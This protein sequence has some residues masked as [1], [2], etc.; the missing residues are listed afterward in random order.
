MKSGIVAFSILLSVSLY[1]HAQTADHSVSGYGWTISIDEKN[2]AL[3]IA[4]DSLGILLKDIHLF[5]TEPKGLREL[6]VWSV[7]AK[8]GNQLSIETAQPRSTWTFSLDTNILR[9]ATSEANGV[10]TAE[11]PAS[12]DRVVARLMDDRGTPVYWVGTSEVKQTYGGSYTQNRSFLP[13]KN[14]ET[15]YFALGQIA[16]G[17]FHSL[18]D[19]ETDAA[20]DFG[21]G[22]QMRRDQ[23]NQDVLD[24]TLPVQG[25]AT[26]RII[27]DYYTKTLG[28]PFYVK[29]DDRFFPSAPIVWTSWSSY[30]QGITEDDIVRN[31][32]WIA[33]HLKPYGFQYVQLDDGY[34]RDKHGAHYWVD[35]WDQTRFPHGPQWLTDHIHSQ[36]LKAGIWLVPNAYAG[37]VQQHPDWY[38]YDKHGALLLDY[39]TPALDSTNPQALQLVKHIFTT[40][41]DW[42][43]DYYK[44]DG[45]GALTKYAPPVDRSRLH[46]PSIDFIANYRDRMK[47]IR[48]TVGPRRFIEGCPMGMPL[49]G[50]GYVSSYFNDDDL[51]T[52]WQG[53]YKMFSSITANAFLNHFL[54][55]VMPDGLQLGPQMTMEEAIQSG[56]R[57]PMVAANDPEYPALTGLGVSMAEAR[58]L[59]SYVALS[60]VEYAMASVMPELPMERVKLL[61]VTMPTLPIVPVDLFS[62]GTAKNW[63]NYPEVLD[64]KVNAPSGVYDVVGLTNWQGWATSRKLTFQSR[65]GL[66]PAQ[67]YVAFDFWNQKVLGTFTRE[68]TVDIPPYDTQVLLIHPLLDH[69]QL[70][71]TSRH[72]TGAY[73]I[74]SLGWNAS[75]HTLSGSS[76]SVDGDPYSVWIYL[77]NQAAVKNIQ[78]KT[79]DGSPVTVQHKIEENTLL[80]TFQGHKEI[81][82]WTVQFAA[83]H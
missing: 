70:L 33:T 63:Q 65:L 46:D 57:V 78:A 39:A 62:R 20:V 7:E 49:N 48:D 8:A 68:M 4:A 1:L 83:N 54:V 15:M 81:V 41:D 2:N 79:K 25:N 75:M 77:P 69:P 38:L 40:L 53:M 5:R 67:K 23:G 30:Y 80:F 66:D 19:R 11:A 21:D 56:S 6:K 60:G 73:S 26:I 13:E 10:I 44:L 82:D 58:T 36:G 45:E 42:G 14:P 35:N 27:P 34:D 24:V 16:G 72:I 17:N 47:L 37:A 3:N 12:S 28:V 64:L 59:V 18:F 43:F 29:F 22:T 50:I 52:S 74:L 76:Q 55:Y 31:A 51:Y 61:Q 9:I 71:G 32:D